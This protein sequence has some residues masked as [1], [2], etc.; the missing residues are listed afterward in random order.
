MINDK[1]ALL[2]ALAISPAETDALNDAP[3]LDRP[4]YIGLLLGASGWV[5]GILLLIVVGVLFQPKT[6]PALFFSGLVL[7]ASAW[8]LYKADRDGAFTG[9]LALA[10]SIAGQVLLVGAFA[11]NFNSLGQPA[12]AAFVLQVILVVIMPNALHRTL[13][14]FFAGAAL[15]AAVRYGLFAEAFPGFARSAVAKVPPSLSYAL[16][17][18]AITWLPVAAGIYWCVR[19]EAMWMARGWQSIARPA[20]AGLIVGLAF[21]T[22]ISHPLEI[23]DWSGRAPVGQGFLALWPL[24]SAIAATGA[25]AAG[26]AMKNR[27]L[28]GIAIFGALLHISHFY[29][30]LGTSLLM[31]SLIMVVMGAAMLGAAVLLKRGDAMTGEAS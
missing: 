18:W 2:A 13:S 26:F 15:A 28:M 17:G 5:A 10:L 14:A 8:G 22:L 9:Q 24:L 3:P 12:F 7:G 6:P 19:H 11:K 20:L 21:A 25:I 16:A 27:A 31:K 30:T 1:H 4:W 29:Y 23:F